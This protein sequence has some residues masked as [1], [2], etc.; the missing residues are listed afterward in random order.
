MGNSLWAVNFIE[1][2]AAVSGYQALGARIGPG[3]SEGPTQMPVAVAGRFTNLGFLSNSP[4]GVAA[5]AQFRKNGANGNQFTSV[6]GQG[7]SQWLIGADTIHGDSVS[8]GDLVDVQLNSSGAYAFPSAW[9]SFFATGNH[10]APWSADMTLTGACAPGDFLLLSGGRGGAVATESFLGP[11]TFTGGGVQGLFINVTANSFTASATFKSRIGGVDGNQAVAIGA[12]LTGIFQ[13]TTHS[14]TFTAGQ[15]VIG[16]MVGGGS[17]SLSYS[18]AGATY[19]NPSAPSNDFWVS[20]VGTTLASGQFFSLFGVGGRAQE[21]F[22]Q[23]AFGFATTISNFSAFISNNTSNG[24]TTLA[25]R[26]NGANANGV[27]SLGAGLTGW[28]I[29]TSHADI[30]QP[31]DL[32]S[33]GAMLTGTSGFVSVNDWVFTQSQLLPAAGAA[34]ASAGVTAI[35]VAAGIGVGH[36]SAAANVSAIGIAGAI[37]AG[38]AASLSVASAVGFALGIG[39]GSA[40]GLAVVAAAGISV[41]VGAGFANAASAATAVAHSFAAALGNAMGAAIVNAAGAAIGWLR[42]RGASTSWAAQSGHAI[43]WALQ[44]GQSTIWTPQSGEEPQT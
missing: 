37:G 6:I 2:G 29:D 11:M 21:N 35:G 28:F 9:G 27:V 5:S 16:H 8:A 44:T 17:S 26:K 15:F 14:D 22:L 32:V 13:D 10:A 23:Q 38:L 12:G 33:V 42:M 36:A 7:G 19:T 20:G 43:G 18:L 4:V 1:G 41:A 24:T 31:A 34:S 3:A 30:F 40:A 25:L 39:A